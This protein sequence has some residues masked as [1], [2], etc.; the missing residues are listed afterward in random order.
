MTKQQFLKFYPGNAD[1]ALC[2]DEVSKALAEVG[3]LTPLTLI[4]ALATVRVEVGKKWKPIREKATGEAYEGRK[5]LGN[6]HIGDGPKYKGRGYIQLTGRAN[7]AVYEKKLGISLVNTPDV[8]LDTVNS[9]RI[10]A[11]YFR[12]RKVHIACDKKD[13]TKVRK[14]VNGGTNGLDEFLRVVNDYSTIA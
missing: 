6:I 3:I 4:G 14:L 8:A 9:A 1:A 7:Y 10:L 2:Y 11:H 5:D 13:W 12:D